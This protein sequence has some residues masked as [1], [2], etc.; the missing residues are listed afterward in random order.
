MCERTI[1]T[2]PQVVGKGLATLY[3]YRHPLI[4]KGIWTL[5][6]KHE[7]S[8]GHYF[9]IALY[10]E[11]FKDMLAQAE[12]TRETLYIIPI[13][14]SKKRLRHRPFNH[15]EVIARE[16]V[17][18][19]KADNLPIILLDQTLMKIKDTPRQAET[20]HRDTRK[21]NLDKAF[22][23]LDGEELT[24]KSIIIVDDV[25]TTGSTMEEARKT[26]AQFKP[27]RILGIAV[28]H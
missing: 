17:D 6:F 7:R 14:M 5:K 27:K 9:G 8:L 23:V 2:N 3:D 26:L 16:I 24:G 11:F 19:A 18:F 13:P 21:K 25:I 4:K 22:A 1:H 10:R 15:A 12:H 28:A 20:T